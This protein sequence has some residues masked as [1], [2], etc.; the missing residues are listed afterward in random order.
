L[1]EDIRIRLNTGGSARSPD[2]AL[3]I[4]DGRDRGSTARQR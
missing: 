4:D 1:T 3:R 2:P